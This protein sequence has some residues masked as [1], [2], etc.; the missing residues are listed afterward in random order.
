M[1]FPEVGGKVGA[2]VAFHILKQGCKLSGPQGPCRLA[3]GAAQTQVRQQG[4]V[5]TET[6]WDSVLPEE[7]PPHSWGRG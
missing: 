6:N 3:E 2:R 4:A 7:W 1:G 5:G